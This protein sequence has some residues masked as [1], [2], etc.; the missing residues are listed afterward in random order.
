M[1]TAR[2][3]Q[4]AAHTFLAF[5]KMLHVCGHIFTPFVMFQLG[6]DADPVK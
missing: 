2:E 4:I 3:N 6:F 1:V 5:G